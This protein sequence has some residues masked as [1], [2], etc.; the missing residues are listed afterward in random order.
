MYACGSAEEK[1]D[2]TAC[3]TQSCWVGDRYSVSRAW[4]QVTPEL[5]VT[6]S[7]YT[8]CRTVRRGSI[9]DRSRV[10]GDEPPLPEWMSRLSPTD[11]HTIPR[12][13]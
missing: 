8:V 11:E 7:P 12:M 3:V 5:T 1:S 2:C 4:Y 10:G 13:D 6:A 9:W